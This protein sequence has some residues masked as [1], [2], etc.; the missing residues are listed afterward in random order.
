M[1]YMIFRSEG[2][3][4]QSLFISQCAGTSPIHSTPESFMG[5][6]GS[7]PRVTA[8]VMRAVRFS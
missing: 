4:C 2:V 6:F 3:R 7:R 8:Q 1:P 5:T